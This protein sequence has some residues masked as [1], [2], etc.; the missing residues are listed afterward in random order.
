[1]HPRGN[2][3]EVLEMPDLAHIIAR[4]PVYRPV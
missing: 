4:G 2:Q 3:L 1:V